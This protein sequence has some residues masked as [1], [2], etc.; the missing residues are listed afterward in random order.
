M[1]GFL[2]DTNVV[3]EASKPNPDSG[4]MEFLNSGDELWLS[5]VAVHEL[6]YG[7]GILREGRRRDDLRT[8]LSQ[9][10]ADFEDRIIIVDLSVAELGAD[11]RAQAHLTGRELRVPDALIAATAVTNDLALVTRNVRDFEGLAV[12]MVNPWG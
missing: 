1:R 6:R 9:L 8:W 10:Q 4:V 5:A 12:E 2:L 7:I 11:L 3:S